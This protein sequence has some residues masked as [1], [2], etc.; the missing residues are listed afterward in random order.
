V[1]TEFGLLDV[2]PGEIAVVQ[3]GMRFSVALADG[4]ARGYV[5]EVFSGHFRLPDL[6]VI[7]AAPWP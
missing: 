7:G 6:G 5:L 1:T 4:P 2:A 3:R